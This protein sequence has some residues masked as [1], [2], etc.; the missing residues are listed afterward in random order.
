M[1][2][3]QSVK[4]VKWIFGSSD[5]ALFD[6]EPTTVLLSKSLPIASSVI[7]LDPAGT[8]LEVGGG[9][10]LTLKSVLDGSSV[11]ETSPGLVV[12]SELIVVCDDDDDSVADDGDVENDLCVNS[13]FLETTLGLLDVEFAEDVVKFSEIFDGSSLE[14]C[15]VGLSDEFGANVLKDKDSDSVDVDKASGDTIGNCDDEDDDG[16][17][18]D[19]NVSVGPTEVSV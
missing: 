11:D 10:N 8:S 3:H 16:D 4:R 18:D 15:N 13:V 19:E 17:A 9:V 1:A 12:G 7:S 5:V 14:G 2:C 6:V